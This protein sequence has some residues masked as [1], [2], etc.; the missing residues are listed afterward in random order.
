MLE[1]RAGIR[2]FQKVLAA[3]AAMHGEEDHLLH[4]ARIKLRTLLHTKL[5]VSGDVLIL[6]F[7]NRLHLIVG[8]SQNKN[9]CS[10]AEDMA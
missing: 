10:I 7:P 9:P 6:K 3:T 5:V 4:R 2:S 8:Q 1:T